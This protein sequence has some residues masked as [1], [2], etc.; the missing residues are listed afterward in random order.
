MNDSIVIVSAARTPMGG[1][2][3][4]FKDVTAAELGAAAIRAAV[5]RAGLAADAVDEVVMGCVLPAGQGQAPARQ[6]ALG[7]GLARGTVCSTL[8]KM[9]GSGMKAAMLGHDLLLAGSA[10]VVIAGGMESMSNAPYLLE[11]ARSGYRMGHGRVLDHMFLD[12]LEDAYDKGRL[13]GTF[14]EDC[15]EAY[16]FSREAQDRF[17]IAS[18][19]RAQQAIATGRFADEI[20]PVQ[21]KAGR[22]LR[23]VEH[24]EQPPKAKLD[25]IPTLKPAFREGGSVTAANSSSISDGAAALVLMRLSEAEKRGLMPLA[26]IRGHASFADAPNLYPTAPIGAVRRLMERTGWSLDGVD[27]FEVNEAFAVVA[28]AAMRD[29]DLPHDK[30]NV[31]GGACALGHPIGAS[32]ARIL[33]TLLSALKQ[34]DLKRG[35]AAICIGGGEATAVAVERL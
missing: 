18:L 31:H 26:A 32:G 3:G 4:D 30:L 25:K 20:V 15:A 22:E 10:G 1:F 19:T 7:A 24:D 8:N 12:G 23:T 21:A 6:A 34:Y 11:R 35:V 27:L 2:L 16:G 14:A 33:V 13:M 5:E 29:L 17:A 9:C 28:M